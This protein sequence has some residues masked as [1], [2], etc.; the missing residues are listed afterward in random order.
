MDTW[1]HGPGDK[2][3]REVRRWYSCPEKL[4]CPIP[5]CTQ[6]QDGW[7]AG[8]SELVR[9]SP[10]HSRGWGWVGFEIPSNPNHSVIL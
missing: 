10:A 7:G 4:W 1:I 3:E 2:S 5:A 9:G 6:G 8:Q